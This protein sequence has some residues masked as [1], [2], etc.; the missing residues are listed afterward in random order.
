MA[1]AIKTIP[2][3]TVERELQVEQVV[4][5]LDRVNLTAPARRLRAL[6]DVLNDETQVGKFAHVNVYGAFDPADIEKRAAEESM[7]EYSTLWSSLEWVRNVLVLVPITLTWFSF[8]L[9]A[10]DYGALLKAR[11]ELAGE[12][13]LYLWESGFAGQA[14]VPFLTFSQTALIAAF[15]LL[16]IIVLTVLV[17]YRKDVASTRASNDAARI[18][19]D[20]E[21]ALWEIEKT[22]SIKRRTDSEAG[23]TEELTHAVN[24]FNGISDQMGRA[25]VQMDSGA[26]EWI[27]LTKDL[28]FRLAMVVNQMQNEADGLRVFSNGLTGNVDRMFGNL[29]SANQT[30]SQLTLAIER[31]SSAIQADTVLHEDKLNDI[32]AQLNVLEEEA[33]G[34][35]QALLKTSDDL[36]VASDKSSSAVASVTGAVV[37]VTALLKG[38]EEMRS[39]LAAT[40][41]LLEEQRRWMERMAGSGA[42][43]GDQSMPGVA[44]QLKASV[45]GLARSNAE[46]AQ[47]QVNALTQIKTE[48]SHTMRAFLNERA[49]IIQAIEQQTRTRERA[50]GRMSSAQFVP[51][52][53]AVAAGVLMSSAIVAG[54]IFVLTRLVGP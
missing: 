34:W 29:E 16:I 28:D 38:Q 36:R 7:R 12:S 45:D 31:L 27:N 39:T 51:L 1:S 46:M 26:R 32:A 20:F 54:A 13:F 24:Q 23:A 40:Q 19:A 18:R 25:V 4:A 52:S 49:S 33:K 6:N 5:Q 9:A 14:A 11:P 50:S 15:F 21:D 44:A 35:G 42:M 30:S 37:T 8:W 53:L 22:L 41:Q 10:Q 17:H 43:G 47:Q 2:T 48:I 3:V